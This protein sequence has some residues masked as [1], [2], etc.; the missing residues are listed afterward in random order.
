MQRCIELRQSIQDLR[1]RGLYDAAK[2]S[3]EQLVGL[4]EEAL[5]RAQQ[6][7]AQ[8]SASTSGKHLHMP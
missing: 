2:W 4:P 7:A 6:L 1:E 3:A 5:A 8:Q